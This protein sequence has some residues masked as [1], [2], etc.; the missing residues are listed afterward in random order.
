[1]RRDRSSERVT[2]EIVIALLRASLGTGPL[3]DATRVAECDWARFALLARHHGIGPILFRAF[4][5]RAASVP[6][7]WLQI[8]KAE[9]ATN[10]FHNQ[11]A[12][13]SVD[14]IGAVLS[15]EQ[16]PVIL[17][18]G[19]ALLRTL[20]DDQGLR[21]L[22][23][24]D[25]LVDERDVER[26]DTQLQ[27][28]GMKL[29]V[30][31]EVGSRCHYSLVYCWQQPRTVPVELHWRIFE[32]YRPYIFDLD[33]VRA[34]ARP[35]PGMPPNVLVMA[36]EHELAHLCLHLDR[37][38]ITY[39][40]LIGRKDWCESL[41]L[42]HGSGRLVWLYDI[43]LYLQRRRDLID[44][45]RFVDTARRWAIDGRVYATLELSRRALGVGPPPEVLQALNRGRPQLVERIAHSVVLASHRANE[46]QPTA[47]ARTPRPHWLTRLSVPILRFAHTWISVFPP[48]AYLHAR[49]A[50]PNAPLWLRGAHLRE[51]VPELWA[52]TRDRLRS[53]AAVRTDRRPR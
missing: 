4:Q 42:P 9:Y 1:M 5:E 8:F 16:I 36:P 7:E 23:D 10:A 11:L 39:R 53:A 6:A 46:T 51:V 49:Y 41:L 37:H 35:L 20:Y 47:S 44:W 30:S 14:E 29:P 3:P 2:S 50:T 21:T 15:S 32:R 38:A 22:C 31:E 33:A 12:H 19:A 52:E 17:M 45:D 13:A 27:A 18:K 28:R 40:S 48:N 34:Q 25:L 26:A 43:A 24:V